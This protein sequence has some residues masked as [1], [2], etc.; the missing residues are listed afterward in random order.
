M[1]SV[2]VKGPAI[3]MPTSLIGSSGKNEENMMQE[4]CFGDL[5]QG[6]SPRVQL[7]VEKKVYV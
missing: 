6:E 1:R 7:W 3:S 5:I 2:A 4:K